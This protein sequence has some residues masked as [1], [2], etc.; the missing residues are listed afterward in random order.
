MSD[1]FVFSAFGLFK[2][3]DTQNGPLSVFR[4]FALEI[5][6]GEFLAILGGS[7]CGK[8][9]LLR[10]FAG[11]VKPDSGTLLFKGAPVDGPHREIGYLP[12]SYDLFP[13]KTVAGN[14]SLGLRQL[15]L[16]K[17]EQLER[18][19]KLVHTVNLHG[20]EDAY[21]KQLSGGMRQRVALARTLATSPTTLLLDEPF[22]A[23]DAKNREELGS[24]VRRIFD[25]GTVR[26]V[27]LIAHDLEEAV[28][29][30]DRVIL[31]GPAPSG[32]VFA[33]ATR[34]S[35]AT[36]PANADLVAECRKHLA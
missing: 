12:Q 2:S 14:I 29:H 15:R 11:I 35:T 1:P 22:A 30:A 21:P 23:L 13:W 6:D 4:N 36:A 24:M 19:A 10:M 28:Q 26:N 33:S 17:A 31:L 3:Y 34:N 5:R 8:S 7:G 20:F 16:S 27:V 32:I 25:E 9:T 18:I